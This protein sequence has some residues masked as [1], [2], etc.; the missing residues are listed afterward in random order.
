VPSYDQ[1][2]SLW[3]ALSARKPPGLT[4]PDHTVPTGRFFW[5]TLPRH[6]VPGYDRCCPYGTKYILRAEALIKLA[7]MRFQSWEALSK[8]IAL[9]GRPL[10]RLPRIPPEMQ[11]P[12]QLQGCSRWGSFPRINPRLS[13]HGPSGHRHDSA[14][15]QAI[16]K[17]SKLQVRRP[18]LLT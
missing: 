10:M 5:G 18:G 15:I 2:P 3:E 6:F 12:L 9:K 14:D 7:L 4:A 11:M 8:R 13:S 1:R 17:M 16:R